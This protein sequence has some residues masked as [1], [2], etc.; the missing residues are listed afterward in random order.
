MGRA[1]VTGGT[2]GIGCAIVAR[3]ADRGMQ[4]LATGRT[5]TSVEQARAEA[6]DAVTVLESDAG[7]PRDI[8]RLRSRVADDFGELDVL[9]LDAGTAELTRLGSTSAAQFD[10]ILATNLTGPFLAAQALAPLMRRGGSIVLTTSAGEDQGRADYHA[11]DASKAALRSVTRG[12][13][14]A[15]VADGI[16]VNAVMPGSIRTSII[17][18]SPYPEGVKE[19]IRQQL[20]AMVPMGRLGESDEVAAAVEFLAFD[21]TFTTGA[22]LPV[23]GGISQL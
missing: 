4:V 12:L 10:R 14:A 11:Y 19:R 2:A 1:V 8:E 21:A 17:E 13:A 3:F 15:L 22:E 18:R 16:R 9:V 7:D 5:A 6:G 20:L 23:D